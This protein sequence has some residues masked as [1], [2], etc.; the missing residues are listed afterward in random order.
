[1]SRQ[2]PSRL[3]TCPACAATIT[4]VDVLVE[5]DVNGQPAVWAD[6]PDCREVVH[7]V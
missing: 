6:C 4:A 1:M 5:Y 3:G 7:P 2:S